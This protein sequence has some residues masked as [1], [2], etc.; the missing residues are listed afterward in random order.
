[1]ASNFIHLKVVG[2]G[3]FKRGG[4]IEDL[5]WYLTLETNFKLFLE[6]LLTVLL[7]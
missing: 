2:G 6:L 1:M 3:F 4:L 5:K 7:V